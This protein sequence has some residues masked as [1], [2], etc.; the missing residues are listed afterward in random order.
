MTISH[1]IGHS[2]WIINWLGSK[3]LHLMQTLTN[4]EQE[5]CKSSVDLFNILNA[6]FKPKHN[7]N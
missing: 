6:K 5:A 2:E 4:G 7:E 1:D 3:E